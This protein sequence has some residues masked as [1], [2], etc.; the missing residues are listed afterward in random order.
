MICNFCFNII[1]FSLNVS[2]KIGYYLS[3]GLQRWFFIC[4]FVCS[5]IISSRT[6]NQ[7]WF[8]CFFCFF[9]SF[10]LLFFHFFQ[11]FF[12]LFKL[13]FNSFFKLVI[14][15]FNFILQIRICFLKSFTSLVNCF[16]NIFFDSDYI[17]FTLFNSFL[18]HFFNLNLCIFN[19]FLKINSF[20]LS[21]INC[22]WF[23]F[24]FRYILFLII[25]SRKFFFLHA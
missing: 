14:S 13:S 16:Q 10:F 25:I 17:Y 21:L 18:N 2:L 23:W 22:R 12:S 24:C 8:S 15:F 1:N 6:L 4:W 9:N 20:N 11:S 7:F 3:S 19:C 5:L